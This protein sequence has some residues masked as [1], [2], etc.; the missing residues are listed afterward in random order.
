[1]LAGMLLPLCLNLGHLAGRLVRLSLP[2]AVHKTTG[3]AAVE[4]EV[5]V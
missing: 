3:E 1:M 4:E 5:V 2:I